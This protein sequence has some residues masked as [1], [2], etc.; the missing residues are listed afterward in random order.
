MVKRVV[1][2]QYL[3][4]AP[5]WHLTPSLVIETLP[6]VCSYYYYYYY[7]GL[8]LLLLS[9]GPRSAFLSFRSTLLSFFF[10]L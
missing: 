9:L 7:Y 6:C 1:K 2:V 10:L 4:R 3:P 8:L 5:C